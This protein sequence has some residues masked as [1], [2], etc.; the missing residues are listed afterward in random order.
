[1]S[2]VGSYESEASLRCDCVGVGMATC[3]FSLP[4]PL[5]LQDQRGRSGKDLASQPAS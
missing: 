5:P 2:L 3:H 4:F 1:M